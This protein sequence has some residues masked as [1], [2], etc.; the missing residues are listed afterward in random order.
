M[1]NLRSKSLEQFLVGIFEKL[2]D[3][4]GRNPKTSVEISLEILLLEFFKTSNTDI[5]D[6]LLSKS[7][8]EALVELQKFLGK[9]VKDS[10]AL[11]DLWKTSQRVFGTIIARF[12]S[13]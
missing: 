11:Q 6:E 8:E 2:N 7:I 13:M 12:I 3:N 1:R 9:F 5:W 10:L 4:S